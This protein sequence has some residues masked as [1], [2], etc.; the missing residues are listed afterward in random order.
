[1]TKQ[2]ILAMLAAR[3]PVGVILDAAVDLGFQAAPCLVA[4]V[5]AQ[6]RGDLGESYFAHRRGR[7]YRVR[8][9]PEFHAIKRWALTP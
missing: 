3:A 4:S 6:T 1:M 8:S 7:D 9:M 5:N 2:C